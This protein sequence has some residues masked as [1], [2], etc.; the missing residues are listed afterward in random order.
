MLPGAACSP[1]ALDDG[2][3]GPGKIPGGWVNPLLGD[4]QI[5]IWSGRA[6]LKTS[7][8]HSRTVPRFHETASWDTAPHSPLTVQLELKVRL[9]A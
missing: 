7:T 6:S 1:G 9:V 5:L 3:A 2:E 8:H 4:E